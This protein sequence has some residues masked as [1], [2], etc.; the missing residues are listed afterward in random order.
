[1]TEIAILILPIVALVAMIRMCMG[2]WKD[3][4]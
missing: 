1:M 3:Y 2:Y 4:D